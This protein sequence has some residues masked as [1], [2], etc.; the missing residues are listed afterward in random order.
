[1]S[2]RAGHLVASVSMLV[3]DRVVNKAPLRCSLDSRLRETFPCMF[4]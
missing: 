4:V 1:M 2:E 3:N